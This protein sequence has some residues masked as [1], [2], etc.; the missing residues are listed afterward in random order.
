MIPTIDLDAWW[1]RDPGLA[2]A[3]DAALQRAGFLVI[4]GHG[5]DPGPAVELCLAAR[6][7]FALPAAVKQRYAARVGGRGWLPPGVEA[8]AGVNGSTRSRS[9]GSPKRPR[10]AGVAV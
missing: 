4:T 6:R 3:V 9:G 5:V 8:D 2:P 7:F 1:A 10:G